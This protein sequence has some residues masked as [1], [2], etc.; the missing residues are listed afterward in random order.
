MPTN[1]LSPAKR[2]APVHLSQV[3]GLESQHQ[4]HLKGA[5]RNVGAPLRHLTRVQARGVYL[6]V[7]AFPPST[8]F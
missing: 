2:L 8:L 7:T 1:D 4:E 3:T 5:Q 6:R